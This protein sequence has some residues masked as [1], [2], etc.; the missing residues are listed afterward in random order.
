M[1]FRFMYCNLW[2]Y[3][4]TVTFGFPNPKKNSV[5]GNYMR[6]YCICFFFTFVRFQQV[7]T[8]FFYYRQILASKKKHLFFSYYCQI[9]WSLDLSRFTSVTK[10][11]IKFLPLHGPGMATIFDHEILSQGPKDR[12]K[13]KIFCIVPKLREPCLNFVILRLRTLQML[14]QKSPFES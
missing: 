6:K 2:L 10:I 9:L 11:D 4:R 12:F 1:V 3:V 8:V 13:K 7:D 14:N 5:C